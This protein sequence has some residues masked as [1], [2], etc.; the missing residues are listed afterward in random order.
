MKAPATFSWLGSAKPYLDEPNTTESNGVVIGRYGGFTGAGAHKN[1]DS[2]LVWSSP[3]Q[4][5]IFATLLDAHAGSDSA[6]A[7]LELITSLREELVEDLALPTGQAFSS[8]QNRL[9]EAF[10]DP[11]F[12]NECR[13][14]EGET[15]CLICAQKGKQLWWLSVGDCVI[16]L[17]HPELAKLGQFALNQR[18]FFE[19]IGRVN[20]FDSPAPSFTVGTRE[21]RGGL[22]HIAMLTDGLLE[23]GNRPFEDPK[24]LSDIVLKRA[25]RPKKAVQHL[26]D[27]VHEDG[28]RDSATIIFWEYDNI[29]PVTYPSG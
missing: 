9:L 8:L 27:K 12:L 25:V 16:Y 20:S 26:L 22:N 4:G 11:S 15:A 3:D 7:V 10:S 21:L 1:E 23:F 17:F 19:W 28:G 24:A 14:L 2:A 5:W 18:Q 13:S 29:E 6:A